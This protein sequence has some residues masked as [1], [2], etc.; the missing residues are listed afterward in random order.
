MAAAN[1]LASFQADIAWILYDAG[2]RYCGAGPAAR[3]PGG[4]S[5]D[6]PEP[7]QDLSQQDEIR[8]L[9]YVPP[10]IGRP[11]PLSRQRGQSGTVSRIVRHRHLGG[12]PGQWRAN[13]RSPG[14]GDCL[15]PRE[16]F[17]L[18]QQG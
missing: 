16:L 12:A 15:R 8:G 10:G 7:L 2:K 11:R 14:A 4:P 9:R 13:V 17:H 18:G 1:P 6:M 5:V 3:P